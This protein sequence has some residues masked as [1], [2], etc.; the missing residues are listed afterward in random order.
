MNFLAKL[1][2]AKEKGLL[3]AKNMQGLLDFYQNY[4][5]IVNDESIADDFLAIL[6]QQFTNPYQFEPYHRAIH[7]PFD[8]YEF[9]MRFSRPLVKSSDVQGLETLDT[10]QNL[11]N[12]KENAVL[13]GNHQTEMD[14]QLFSIALEEKYPSIAKDVIF[15]AGD[16]VT[17]DPFAI[18]FSMGRNLLCI[19]SKRHINNPPEKRHEKQLHN[20]RTMKVMRDLLSEGGKCIYVAPS[21]G[22]DRKNEQGQI[23]VSEF[24]PNN[25]EM[26]RLMA[27]HATQKTHFYPLS[28]HTY[29]ILPPPETVQTEL[30]ERRCFGKNKI[31]FHFAP[32]VDLDNFPGNEISDR[33]L[34]RKA[35]SD[36][37]WS[38][39]NLHYLE[40][41]KRK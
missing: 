5:S 24:D 25:I 26:F 1:E 28:L 35:L 36:Y 37:V 31:L 19:Y 34:R 16:R 10:I 29:D 6:L 2:K 41:L 32:E 18:P 40:L 39:V 27:H 3:S 30:G 23:V 13:F 15:V 9:G 38:L 17:T 22:R 12:K 20:Q 4:Q 11:L 33:I 7:E 8:Y 14:P 21:G